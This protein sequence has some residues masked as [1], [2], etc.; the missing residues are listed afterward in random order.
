V[1][2]RTGL[3]CFTVRGFRCIRDW[4]YHLGARDK[5]KVKLKAVCFVATSVV[6]CSPE[7]TAGMW[8]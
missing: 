3:I 2:K 6:G 8:A 1:K 7:N 4:S 5:W